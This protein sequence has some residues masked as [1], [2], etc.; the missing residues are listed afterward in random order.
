MLPGG[1]IGRRASSE[2]PQPASKVGMR[3]I[4]GPDMATNPASGQSPVGG[5]GGAHRA[6][7]RD[8]VAQSGGHR[9][10]CRAHQFADLE[11]VSRHFPV[12]QTLAPT[13][14]PDECYRP[15]KADET[16]AGC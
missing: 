4:S 11:D 13:L 9:W 16:S 5:V 12:S 10:R 15:R 6:A 3:D 2:L 8:S 1:L 7:E 14:G